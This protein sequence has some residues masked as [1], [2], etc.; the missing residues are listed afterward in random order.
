MTD[1]LT[2]VS[3]LCSTSD[4]FAGLR[5]D[6]SASSEQS[7]EQNIVVDK[8]YKTKVKVIVRNNTPKGGFPIPE[9][10]SGSTGPLAN[11][12]V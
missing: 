8:R 4:D 7:P 6:V 9:F 2:S 3:T 5:R 11:I 1:L 12:R 10:L